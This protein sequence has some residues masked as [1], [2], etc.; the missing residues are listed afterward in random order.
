ML[1]TISLVVL[2]FEEEHTQCA[3]DDL[4]CHSPRHVS[5]RI[6]QFLGHVGYGIRR[7]NCKSS[8]Q[9]AGQECDSIAP[10]RSV[11]LAEV[12]PDCRIA[13]MYF[14]HRCDHDDGYD[15]TDNDKKQSNLIQHW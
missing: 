14:G 10:A 2:S 13:G 6:W 9:H 15:S 11:V 5:G 3:Q 1:A 7:A 12:A 8:V 4:C